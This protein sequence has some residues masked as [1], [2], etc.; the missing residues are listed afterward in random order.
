LDYA[1]VALTNSTAFSPTDVMPLTRRAKALMAVESTLSI[2]TV[3][4]VAARAV[5]VLT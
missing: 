2:V 1:Y 5:N 3:L 4:I